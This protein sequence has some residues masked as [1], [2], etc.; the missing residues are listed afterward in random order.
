MIYFVKRIAFSF[1]QRRYWFLAAF[2]PPL[3]F[4]VLSVADADRFLI[5]QEVSLRADRALTPRDVHPLFSSGP[6]IDRQGG[7]YPILPATP[8]RSV[9]FRLAQG[10]LVSVVYEGPDPANGSD[11]VTH[12]VARMKRGL[13][14]RGPELGID[15]N[16]TTVAPLVL[17][18][19]HALWRPERLKPLTRS[20]G[21]SLLTVLVI[22]IVLEFNDPS[23]KTERAAARYT[24]IPML[25]SLPDMDPLL[26]KVGHHG[27]E[28][29]LAHTEEHTIPPSLG[30]HM[31]LHGAGRGFTLDPPSEK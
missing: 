19:Q 5:R 18:G 31:G 12:F 16:A 21:L 20:F 3:V 23:F 7:E 1:I 17:S 25:G 11:L 6:F 14:E 15:D 27:T 10:S 24:G 26:K 28:S 2:F 22:L 29:R 8:A 9:F 30:A 13:A 4:L